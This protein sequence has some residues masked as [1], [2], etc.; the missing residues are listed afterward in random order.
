MEVYPSRLDADRTRFG[1]QLDAMTSGVQPVQADM[2]D[3]EV[4]QRLSIMEDRRLLATFWALAPLQRIVIET[5]E[6]VLYSP[7]RQVQRKVLSVTAMCSPTCGSFSLREP[8]GHG[9]LQ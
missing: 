9:H 3:P 1:A 5:V 4:R 6:R 8:T 2:P 7:R